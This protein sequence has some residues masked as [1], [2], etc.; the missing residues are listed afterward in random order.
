MSLLSYAQADIWISELM[1]TND[2]VLTDQDG[3]SSDWIEI[4]N[5][6]NTAVDLAGWHLSDDATNLSKWTFPSVSVPAKGFIVVFASG[7][8]RRTEGAELHTNFSLKKSGEYLGIIEPNGRTVAHDYAPGYPGQATDVSYGLAQSGTTST[9]IPQSASG[10]AGVAANQTDFNNN[11]AGWNTSIT[12]S[13]TGSTWRDV[14]SGVGYENNSGYGNWIGTGGDFGTNMFNLNSSVFLRL[15]FSLADPNVI[16]GLSLRMRWDAG[17]VAYINGVKVAADRDPASP[18]WNS[19]ATS[20]RPDAQNDDW[21]TFNI[22]LNTIT[23]NAGNNLLAIHGLND[24]V[25]SSDMLCLPELDATSSPTNSTQVVYFANPSPGGINSGGTA[26]IPPLV[27][28]VTDTF[29]LLPTGGGG[30]DPLFITARITETNDP[31]DTVKLY[32][33]VMFGSETTLTMKDDGVVPDAVADDGFYSVYVPTTTLSAGQM[34][35]WRVEVADDQGNSSVLPAYVDPND[36]D[37]Y[38]GTIAAAPSVATSDLPVLHWFVE[39]PSAATTSGGTRASY[40]FLGRFYDNI[41]VDKHGQTTGGFAKKSFDIDFNKG[42]RFTWKEG[43]GKAKDINLLTNWADKTKMRNTMAYEVFRDSGAAH[44]FAFPVRVQQNAA[45]FSVADMVED[46]DDRYLERIGFDGE[47]SLYKM[48]DGLTSTGS[49]SKKTRKDEDKSDLQA[50]ITNLGGNDQNSRRLY[51]YDNVDIPETVNY[52]ASLVLA[53]SKDQGHKN[54]YVYRDTNNTGE[55]MPLVWDLDLSLGHDWGGQGSF[56]DDIITTQILQFGFSNRLKTLIWDS[57]ELNAMFVRRVRSLMDQLLEPIT[58][59]LAQRRMENRIEELAALIDPTGVTSDAALDFTEWGSWNDGSSSVINPPP[60]SSHMRLQADRLINDYLSGRRAYLYGGSPSSDGL[61]IPSEQQAMPDITIEDIEFLPSSGNQNEEYFVL[62]NRESQAIDISGWEI[63]GA[64]EMTFKGGTIIP[65]GSGLV[66]SDYIG[67]LHVAKS[68]IDF[69]A[70][71]SG[72]TGGQYRLIQ[73]GYDGQLSARGETI[74]LWDAEGNMIDSKSFLGTPSDAQL[75]LRVSEINYHPATPSVA[76]LALLPGVT[77]TDFEFI[78]LVNT[79]ATTLD[80]SGASFTEGIAYQFD[81][82]VTLTSGG[83]IVIAK[84]IAAF[85]ARYGSALNVVGP[86][87]GLLDNGGERLQIVDALGENILD[88]S[89][90]DKWYPPSDGDGHTLVIRDTNTPYNAYDDPSSWGIS[91]SATGSPGAA[92]AK[93]LVHFEGWRYEKF[94]SIERA[95]PLV[96]MQDSDS[97]LD[98]LNNWAEYCYGM[99]PFKFDAVDSK[100]VTADDS[101]NDYVAIEFT[102]RRDAFDVNWLLKSCDDLASWAVETSSIHGLTLSV[103]SGSEKLT[104]RSST[105]TDAGGKKFFRVEGAKQ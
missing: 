22:D 7:K 43:E 68:S 88:F 62:K 78:E 65:S 82:G 19:S 60:A 21:E 6:D 47:G 105:Q 77:E 16:S 64:V 41:Q 92:D 56:D 36:A 85:E 83:R 45:F 66:S 29:S 98:G 61:S 32:Y 95:D 31:I 91:E 84:N 14:N 59:P 57:P 26:S 71:S 27:D 50:L 46:G 30:S 93:Y 72:A 90:N 97:D 17:F 25:G 67:L 2:S 40:Y 54:Y 8:D 73:G 34:I 37:R 104:L 102:R 89:W 55:W 103:G 96:G 13:F 51:G 44:H 38:Y 39:S 94:T 99:D 86:F 4:Y 28:D 69:R 48:Y 11:F 79:G 23:L 63:R 81:S 80:L 12:G 9:I 42:N 33:R 1:A 74:E 10:R 100:Y 49:A 70:R 20:D 58:V 24:R 18:V 101:G 75:A 53:G 5:D 87:T 35:R 52:L 76:E 3:D 15:P